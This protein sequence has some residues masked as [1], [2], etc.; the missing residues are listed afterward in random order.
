MKLLLGFGSF[1]GLQRNL[2]YA[3]I[4]ISDH[5]KHALCV[6]GI[7][8]LS[9]DHLPSIYVFLCLY[10]FSSYKDTCHIGLGANDIILIWS[11]A[12]TIS[13]KSHIHMY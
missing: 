11:F 4:L 9:L 6:D 10:I 2:F 1:W 8:P 5:F 12:K 3:S 7:L 13:K